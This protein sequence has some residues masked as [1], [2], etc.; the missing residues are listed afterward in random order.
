MKIRN[1]HVL[2]TTCGW[3]LHVRDARVWPAAKTQVRLKKVPRRPEA[4]ITP[5]S[6]QFDTFQTCIC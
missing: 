4:V 1:G 6:P 2:Y 5:E 3:L